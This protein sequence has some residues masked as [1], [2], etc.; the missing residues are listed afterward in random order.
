MATNRGYPRK[1]KERVYGVYGGTVDDPPPCWKCG[2][3]AESVD[4]IIPVALGGTD[5][6]DN[7][8]PACIRCNSVD[9]G[10]L[11]SVLRARSRPG[12]P[13][14]RNSE[15]K[16]A[17]Q[18][19]EDARFFDGGSEAPAPLL[20]E[21]P[22]GGPRGTDRGGDRKGGKGLGDNHP[23]LESPTTGAVGRG[24]EVAEIA[25]R[26]GLE[27][28]PWQQYAADRLTDG[29]KRT[30]LVSAARQN[31][32]SFLLRSL[33]VW[34][35]TSRSVEQGPQTVVHAANTRSLAV[36]QWAAVVRLFEDK[37]PGAIE[38]VTRG[39]GRERLHLVDGSTY[40]PTASTDAVH[41][42]SV[43]LFLVDE[44]WDI[45]QSVLDDGIL[46]T[47]MARPNPLV[48]MFSTAG[49]ESSAAMRSWRERGLADIDSG[50][51]TS[52]LFLEW[53]APEDSDPDDPDTWAA[54][55]PGM[56]RTINLD[57]LLQASKNPNRAAFYRAN[58]NRWVQTER[59]WFP[60]GLW[61]RLAVDPTTVTVD[62]N[63][64]PVIAIE[65]D[66]TTGAFA[67]VTAT[68]T[69]DRR[70]LVSCRTV[71][72]EP[73][74]WEHLSEPI[75][76]GDTVL[77]PPLFPQRSPYDLPDNVRVV[78]DRE[79]RG[80]S[81]IVEQAAATGIVAHDGSVLLAEQLG[82]TVAKP[83]DGGMSLGTAV[84]GASIH[85]VRAFVWAVA[86]ATRLEKPVAAPIIHFA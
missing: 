25:H 83:R 75:R 43:D 32:K 33:I 82:R 35:L 22:R 70:V 59:G 74:L 2:A 3:S 7:L 69:V 26:L 50:E 86:E 77:L 13:A 44:V 5:D 71:A 73:D 41:G 45:K 11:G 10:K 20:S 46:P 60:V 18:I 47:T 72:L 36:D 15:T 58:L 67:I 39:A 76:R 38:K 48:A 19:R 27:L 6:L 1:V 80:W 57:A 9:G 84:P 14:A 54:A 53:S 12:P 62:P 49:D 78:G 81:T 42:L 4:H 16:S 8:R 68:P 37:L 63:R 66:R 51:V 79:L 85:A 29:T 52:H 40:Q 30:A 31:G 56:G 65:Q 55:N 61:R 24:A 34:W 21:I 64:R 23:R 17:R 28:M